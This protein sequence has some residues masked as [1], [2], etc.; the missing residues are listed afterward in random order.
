MLIEST[1][2]RCDA[3]IVGSIADT[4]RQDEAE[5]MKHCFGDAHS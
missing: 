1:C 5:H 3:K 2:I 4:L